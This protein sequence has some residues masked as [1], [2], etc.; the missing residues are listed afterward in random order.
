MAETAQRFKKGKRGIFGATVAPSNQQADFFAQLRNTFQRGVVSAEID[1]TSAWNEKAGMTGARS[2]GQPKRDQTRRIIE[3]HGGQA[4]LHAPLQFDF[5]SSMSLSQRRGAQALKETIEYADDVKAKS[6][7]L[8]PSMLMGAAYIDPATSQEGNVGKSYLLCQ[9]LNELEGYLNRHKVRDPLVKEQIKAEWKNFAGAQAAAFQQKNASFA[10]QKL[11]DFAADASQGAGME[12]F[13]SDLKKQGMSDRAIAE[14]VNTRLARMRR[15]GAEREVQDTA[16]K[17]LRRFEQDKI[18]FVKKRLKRIEDN[19][20]HLKKNRPDVYKEIVEEHG[21]Y[22]DYL[23]YLAEREWAGASA[24]YGGDITR[25]G[26]KASAV[27]RGHFED[28]HK[29][30][31]EE[32]MRN[33][34]LADGGKLDEDTLIELGPQGALFVQSL[35]LQRRGDINEKTE[36]RVRDNFMKTM[37]MLLDDKAVQN[38]LKSGKIQ[39]NL[40]NMWGSHPDH[41]MFEG[42]PFFNDPDNMAE[43]ILE[44][45]EEAKKRGL[46]EEVIGITFDTQHAMASG[47][48]DEEGNRLKPSEWIDRLK[49]KGVD[50]DHAH[51]VGGSDDSKGHAAFG[52][53]DDELARKDPKL[54]AKLAEAG[55]INIE[56][57][58]GLADVEKAI[59]TMWNEGVPLEAMAA[60]AHAPAEVENLLYQ[61]APSFYGEMAQMY[62]EIT[63]KGGLYSFGPSLQQP[64]LT[65]FG[66]EL[67]PGMY[68][69]GIMHRDISQMSRTYMSAQP[70]LYSSGSK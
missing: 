62:G 1:I 18:G 68:G 15:F 22:E 59:E 56:G 63:T 41:G 17:V 55:A 33:N 24:A 53:W 31:R 50:I 6:I 29:G 38:K 65:Q 42:V 58:K 61:G 34:R 60:A 49:K 10:P 14:R 2:I 51:L 67:A 54:F 30:L 66:A 3:E 69:G 12:V 70:M 45:R 37:R 47:V 28:E 64:G 39:L 11:R 13:V 40:E 46:P 20:N 32:V 16:D 25:E 19:K 4:S 35:S 43:V 5:S 52:A 57:S 48:F 44:L 26:F 9:N 7:T 8:H 27:L 21:S 23:K 36:R